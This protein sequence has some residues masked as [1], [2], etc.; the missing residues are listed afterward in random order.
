MS[1]PGRTSPGAVAHATSMNK[2]LPRQSLF[3]WRVAAH[4]G[5]AKPQIETG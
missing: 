4:Q 3:S 2:G 1:A 5:K